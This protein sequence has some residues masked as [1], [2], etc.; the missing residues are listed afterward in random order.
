MPLSPASVVFTQGNNAIVITRRTFSSGLLA[1]TAGSLIHSPTLLASSVKTD[2]GPVIGVQ[3]YSFRDM[4]VAPGDTI[5][6]VISGCQDLGLRSIEL[7]EPL[8]WPKEFSLGAPW[9]W[10]DG[11]ATKASVYGKPPVGPPSPHQKNI[12]ERIRQWRMDTPIDYFYEVGTRFRNA[13]IRIE[14]FNFSLKMDCTDAEAEKGFLMTKALGTRVMS[15]STTW[16]MAQRSVPWMEQHQVIVG[17][18]GHSN[19]TDPNQFAR[20][21]SYERAMDLSPLFGVSLDLGHFHA[22]GFDVMEFVRKHHSR[23]VNV[24][25]KDRQSNFGMNKPL[26][27]GDTP[28]AEV[29]HYIVSNRLPIPMLMEYE[30]DGGDSMTELANMKNFA[31]KAALLP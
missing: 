27:E 20:P 13:G 11:K 26:G 12:R 3:G 7:F 5:D 23:I 4:L 8:L 2:Q 9:A 17:I 21:E 16:E 31:L 1:L 15:T 19:L 6:K 10:V 28:L 25:L 18:H 14:A 24:H 22:A 29:I 30:Y